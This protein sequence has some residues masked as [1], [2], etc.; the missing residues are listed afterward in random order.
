MTESENAQ[1]QALEAHYE[2]MSESAGITRDQVAALAA[3]ARIGGGFSKIVRLGADGSARWRGQTIEKESWDRTQ[4]YAEQ[5]QVLDLWSRVS[6]ASRRYSTATGESEMAALD[7]SLSANLTRMQ[8]Y[9]E[10]AA[11]ARQ[12]SESWSE[13]AAL[14]TSQ[15]QAV[16]RDLAQPFFEWLS[17]RTG[18]DGRAIGAAGALRLATIRTPEDAETLREHAA[19]FIAERFPAPAGPDPSTIGGEA[20]YGAAR[21]TLT[22]AYARETAAAHAGWSEGVRDRSYVA[23][24]PI[25]GEVEAGALGERAETKA[26]MTVREAGR[27]A[28]SS[29]AREDA[30]EG[31]AGVAVETGK[32]FEEHA[33]EKLPFVGEWLAGKLFGTAKNAA[34]DAQEFRLVEPEPDWR[35]QSP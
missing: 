27:E 8:R 28:R 4:D 24:A 17:E 2:K 15:G 14:V 1:V 3:E 29:I 32:P 30:R 13:Q 26:D 34:P 35:D 31:R 9:E 6:E 25:P 10:R 16:D 18:A 33:T 21:N 20:E 5:H 19:A 12:E 11:L 22:D 23:G 7:E